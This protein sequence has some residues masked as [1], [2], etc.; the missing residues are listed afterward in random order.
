MR[1][2][3][4]LSGPSF[5]VFF[6]SKSFNILITCQQYLL[7]MTRFLLKCAVGCGAAIGTYGMPSVFASDER[8]SRPLRAVI[9]GGGCAGSILAKTIEHSMATTL[10]DKKSFFEFTP[11]LKQHLLGKAPDDSD[12]DSILESEKDYFRKYFIPHGYYLRYSDVIVG[13]AKEITKTHV[14]LNNGKKIAYDRCFICTGSNQASPWRQSTTQSVPDRAIEMNHYRKLINA[15]NNIAIIGGGAS[16]CEYAGHI[17]SIHPDKSVTIYH[18][19]QSLAPSHGKRVQQYIK[20]HFLRRNTTLNRL[21]KV[22]NVSFNE[23][24]KKFTI[25]WKYSNEKGMFEMIIFR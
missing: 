24:T 1:I 6:H 25:D 15:S 18:S 8:R 5:E 21:C 17:N 23:D 14:L 22:T 10:I 20:K 16:G 2:A 7:Y 19:R 12:P 13:E 4:T 11:A 3:K 9:V